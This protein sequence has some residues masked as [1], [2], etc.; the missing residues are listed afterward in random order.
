MNENNA[1]WNLGDILSFMNKLRDSKGLTE[2][3][4][5]QIW[6]A[7]TGLMLAVSVKYDKDPAD[8]LKNLPES[9]DFKLM[10]YAAKRVLNTVEL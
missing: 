9:S 1:Q 8:F 10:L 4:E 3:Q 5:D 2:Q 6:L 7:M